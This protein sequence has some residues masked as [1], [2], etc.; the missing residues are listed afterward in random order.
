MNTRLE[1]FFNNCKIGSF[2]RSPQSFR[3]DLYDAS[4]LFTKPFYKGTLTIDSVFSHPFV[5]INGLKS[6][7]KL[8]GHSIL[9]PKA[10]SFRSI[11][12]PMFSASK[13][14]DVKTP[15]DIDNIFSAKNF[16]VFTDDMEQAVLCASTIS[17]LVDVQKG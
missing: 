14:E 9:V 11:G 4:I 6:E 15:Y 1:N 13:V 10:F 3:K 16:S 7:G 5:S 17:H 12:G 8:F 2:Y